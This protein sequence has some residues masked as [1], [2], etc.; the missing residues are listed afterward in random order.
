MAAGW[1]ALGQPDSSD[2]RFAEAAP[3]PPDIAALGSPEFQ[4][5]LGKGAYAFPPIEQSTGPEDRV[6]TVARGDT[7]IG[8][9]T[10][11][12]VARGSAHEVVQRLGTVFDVPRLQLGQDLTLTFQ[13][14]PGGDQFP[15]L[16][17]RPSR[18]EERR[19]GEE[20]ARTCIS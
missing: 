19:V 12:G 10:G 8:I 17:R 3:P 20:G 2:A 4:A 9:L 15:G 6:V 14:N 5:R 13:P 7:L 1:L 11:N 18:P 16:A